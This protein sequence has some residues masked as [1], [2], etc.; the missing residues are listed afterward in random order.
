MVTAKGALT[1][2][3]SATLT[4]T[5]VSRF[6]VGSARNENQYNCKNCVLDVLDGSAFVGGSNTKLEVGASGNASFCGINVSNSTAR[7]NVLYIGTKQSATCSSNDFLHV[8]GAAARVDVRSATADSI[9]LRTGARLKFTLPEN[10][11][12]VTPLTTAGGVTVMADEDVMDVDPVKLVIDPSA[13]DP[14]RSGRR[15]T[16]LT[17]AADSTTSLQ[18]LADNLTFVNTPAR[19]RGQVFAADNGP[20][21]A[22]KGTGGGTT[23]VVQ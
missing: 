10:G 18:R 6:V 22:Y 2:R 23:I 13:F 3:N 7:C 19:K 16:L 1:L 5:N 12:A 8:A 11:Y 21:L 17:C 20:K 9:R 14:D 15:Q 4:A